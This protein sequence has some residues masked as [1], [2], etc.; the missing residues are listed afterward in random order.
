MVDTPPRSQ[1]ASTRSP[2]PVRT[3]KGSRGRTAAHAPAF[4]KLAERHHKLLGRGG[5][6]WTATTS[7]CGTP[8]ASIRRRKLLWRAASLWT[9]TASFYGTPQASIRLR[10]LL[11]RAA[12]LWTATASF[13]GAPQA[14]IRR[15]KLLWLA[16]SLKDRWICFAKSTRGSEAPR[17]QSV[18]MDNAW[19]NTFRGSHRALIC[20]RRG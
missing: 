13:C 18:R 12:S 7:F 19:R 1:R 3:T 10:K 16:F 4:L 9:A 11:W 20:C 6:L 15:R 17:G 5:S 8:Q 14:S 2:R